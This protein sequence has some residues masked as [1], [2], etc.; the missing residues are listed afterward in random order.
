MIT[1]SPQTCFEILRYGI[2]GVT[3][4]LVH[5]GLYWL[6]SF[7]MDYNLAYTVAY[8]TCFIGNFFLTSYFTFRSKATAKRGIGFSGAHLCN[9]LLQI[10]L[11]NLFINIGVNEAI[12]PIPV[13]AIAIP[14]NF[15]MVRFVFK[16]K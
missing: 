1:I 13:F 3:A 10:G 8:G 7:I 12:A 16:H 15:I 4:T 5:Y 14:I 2:V 11:L 9:Y 6:L